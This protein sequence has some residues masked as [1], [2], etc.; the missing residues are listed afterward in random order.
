MSV[1]AC[2][3]SECGNVMCDVLIGDHYVCHECLDE[4][5]QMYSHGEVPAQAFREW[6]QAFLSF[7]A[8]PKASL[9]GNAGNRIGSVDDFIRQFRS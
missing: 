9:R 6:G 8:T 4:F 1:L 2:D 7:M 3:R 5:Q